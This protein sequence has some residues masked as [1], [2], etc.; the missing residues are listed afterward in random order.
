[1]SPFRINQC[2]LRI[3]FIAD[4]LAKHGEAEISN[5]GQ[6]S[7]FIRIAFID[8]MNKHDI[9]ISMDGKE[10]WRENVFAG[11]WW[12]TAKYGEAVLRAYANTPETSFTWLLH[13]PFLQSLPALFEA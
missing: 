3:K 9:A 8:L 10:A 7:K 4:P 6:G 2:G 5:S 13:R 12:R 11:R 1:M